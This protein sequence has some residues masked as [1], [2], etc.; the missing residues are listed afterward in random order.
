MKQE[1]KLLVW[2][3]EAFT[4]LI[5][6]IGISVFLSIII[7]LFDIG[8]TYKFQIQILTIITALTLIATHIYKSIG[9]LSIFRNQSTFHTKLKLLRGIGINTS[10]VIKFTYWWNYNYSTNSGN[11]E[12]STSNG[13]ANQLALWIKI[14][15]ESDQEIELKEVL[16]NWSSTP[17]DWKYEQKGNINSIKLSAIGLRKLRRNISTF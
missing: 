8:N 1:F 2:K 13:P 17:N 15:L 11:T 10:S 12:D 3:R 14:D 7:Y 6:I 9:I 5:W 16:A 4:K